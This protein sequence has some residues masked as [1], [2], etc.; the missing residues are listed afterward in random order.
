MDN[1][2]VEVHLAASYRMLLFLSL[3]NGQILLLEK[4]KSVLIKLSILSHALRVQFWL[5]HDA[6]QGHG[7]G[8]KPCAN[9]PFGRY[10]KEKRPNIIL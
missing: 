9:V 7:Y 4:E 8:S 5:G 6:K 10:L 2:R 3:R 1:V